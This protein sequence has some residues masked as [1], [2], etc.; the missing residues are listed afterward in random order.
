MKNVIWTTT[1][2][3]KKTTTGISCIDPLTICFFSNSYVLERKM[4]VRYRVL[5]S[6]LYDFLEEWGVLQDGIASMTAVLN[7]VK[8]YIKGRHLFDPRNPGIIMCDQLLENIF[9]M[10]CLYVA[11]VRGP[12]L[13][14]MVP[15]VPQPSTPPPE[16]KPPLLP[17]T[18]PPSPPPPP[19]PAPPPP[20]L[21]PE[22]WKVSSSLRTI[23]GLDT[24]A[25][26]RAEIYALFS[27]YVL[28]RRHT[29]FD[30]RNIL[31]CIVR[32]DPMGAVLGVSA[33]HRDQA[34]YLLNKHLTPLTHWLSLVI[35]D[36][37]RCAVQ[38]LRLD[39]LL[40]LKDRLIIFLGNSGT[41]KKKQQQFSH[42]I[43]TILLYRKNNFLP[44][45]FTTKP[46]TTGVC[47]STGQTGFWR[48]FICTLFER[49]LWT[50]TESVGGNSSPLHHILW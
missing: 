28:A 48:M 44:K 40:P 36:K 16:T 27:K 41:G 39:E 33:F 37:K 38:T 3:R 21:L 42:T 23:L 18:P 26:T 15:L 1:S 43:H 6:P 25:T 17:P 4:P 32:N 47:E 30:K 29:L 10:K 31:I 24:E 19:Q 50:R 45:T 12:L 8:E 34:K 46:Q 14:H 2:R 11:Q 13:K 5:K 22:F 49:R 7:T 35:P 20:L 9:D